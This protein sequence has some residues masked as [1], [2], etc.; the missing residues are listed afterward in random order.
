[1]EELEENMNVFGK[2]LGVGLVVALA[3]M[4]AAPGRSQPAAAR[5]PAPAA[6]ARN[7]DVAICLDISGSMDGLIDSAKNKSWNIVNELAKIKPTPNLRVALYTYG[8]DSYDPNIGWIKKDLDLTTDLD[9]LYQKLF[10][11]RTNGGTE[12]VT[13]VCR[14]A[15][16][17]LKWSDDKDALK[18]IF[19]CG[20]EPASQDPVVKLKE[21]AD[22]AISKGVIVNPIY[23]GNPDDA[24]ARDWREFAALCGGR[25][26]TI[27]Q[28]KSRV[29]I[30]TPVD[31]QLAELGV[32]LNATY[33][34]YGR[35]GKDKEKN[36]AEQT[37]NAA[38]Q[39]KDVAAARALSQSN[40]IYKCVDW[41]LVDRMKA[42]PKLDISKIPDEELSP[43]MKKLK[44][45]ERVTYVKDMAAKREALQ[46]EVLDLEKQRQAFIAEELKRNPNPSARAFDAAINE[47][48]RIQ[49][50]SKGIE[51]PK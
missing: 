19:V 23:C 49:A 7:I 10:A 9:M 47:T 27:D 41:D 17:D 25:F 20:N 40:G 35:D 32:K 30:A 13:R 4:V 44:P 15:V 48:L 16:R 42:D 31:K 33:V 43:E 28:D 37:A 12:Y 38:K 36:Q 1:M 24:D 21:A 51:I 45:A 5:A 14:D 26:A 50:K 11:L 29:A 2:L 22:F 6:K 3:A 39:G 34:C 8:H 46:K 18:L